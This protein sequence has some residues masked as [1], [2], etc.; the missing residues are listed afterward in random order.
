MFNLIKIRDVELGYTYMKE[1]ALIVSYK[2][3]IRAC[4]NMN[5]G[6]TY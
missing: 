3:V 4:D 2:W 6:I 5:E 1:D